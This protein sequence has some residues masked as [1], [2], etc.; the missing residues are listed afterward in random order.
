MLAQDLLDRV[1]SEHVSCGD[2]V[3]GRLLRHVRGAEALLHEW[4]DGAQRRKRGPR[5]GL[6][7]VFRAHAGQ[8]AEP[9]R[10][11]ASDSLSARTDRFAN[12]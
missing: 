9:G 8:D 3:V 5:R 6:Q 7:I 1:L 11:S 12:H 2:D 4:S 10:A